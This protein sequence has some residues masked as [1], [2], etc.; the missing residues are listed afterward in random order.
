MFVKLCETKEFGQVLVKKEQK[1]E[2]PEIKIYSQPSGFNVWSTTMGIIK[3]L[4]QILH[5]I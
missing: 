2:G 5:R 4:G 3:H 1:A